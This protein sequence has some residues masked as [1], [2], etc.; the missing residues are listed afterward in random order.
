MPKRLKCARPIRGLRDPLHASKL[1]SRAGGSRPRIGPGRTTCAPSAP[2]RGRPP[3]AT[4]RVM[5]LRAVLFDVDFTLAKPGPDL[6]PEGY[7]RLGARFGLELDP[8]RYEEARDARSSTLERHPGARPRRGDLVRASRS[9]SSAG[10]GGDGRS[11]YDVRGRDDAR[12]G[13][14]TRTSSS[15]TTSLPALAE[16][17]AARASSSGSSRTRPRRRRVRRPPRARRRRGDQLVRTT[18]R[19]SRTPRSSARCST[20]SASSRPRLR[21]SATRSRTTS[22]APRDRDA[23]APARPRGPLPGRRAADRR[24][25]RPSGR[26]R[27]LQAY[28]AARYNLN[29]PAWLI[30]ADRRGPRSRSARSC[31]PGLFFLGP[32]ALAAVACRGRRGHRRRRLASVGRLLAGSAGLAGVPPADRAAHLHMPA[33]TRTGTAALVGAKALVLAA[34]RRQRRPRARSAARSGRRARSS[35]DE[36][37]EPGTQVEV[38]KIEGATALVYE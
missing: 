14:R 22:K 36:V 28:A 35:T 17:R 21:W 2:C 29:V 20:C 10:M 15:T 18:A 1:S 38:A 13:A 9:G 3:A 26:A 25:A 7:R 32:V 27:A 16:L 33:R 31:T 23:R 4:S 34:G 37:F 5:P 11:A 6:G 30:W 19:R 24:S 8:A 12:L